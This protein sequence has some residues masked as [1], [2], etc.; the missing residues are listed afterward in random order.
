VRRVS[1]RGQVAEW[2]FNPLWVR[3]DMEVDE[4]FGI[5]H[6]YLISRGHQIQIARFL[7]PDE[8]ASFYKGLVEALNAAKRGPTYNPVS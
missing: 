1:H 7:G 4:D 8:K 3:L 6:L 5:E 2:T